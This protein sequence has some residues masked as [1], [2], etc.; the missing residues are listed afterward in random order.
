M[1]FECKYSQI[2]ECYRGWPNGVKYT[3]QVVKASIIEPAARIAT[4]KGIHG[5]GR[6]NI[7]VEGLW[8][9]NTQVEY[10]PRGLSTTFPRLIS[11][12][13]ENCGI[14]KIARKD[15]EG[16]GNL[17]DLSLS[18]NKLK[19]LP[20]D[21][22]V[23][24]PNLRQIFL[25]GNKILRLSSKILDPLNLKNLESFCLVGN[26]SIN[27]DFK[28]GGATTLEILMKEIDTKCLPPIE[29]PRQPLTKSENR[30]N[31][32][33]EYFL[34]GKFSDSIIKFRGKE[35]KVHKI[36]LLAQSSMIES[37]IRQRKIK[38]IKNMSDVAFED[39]LRYFYFGTIKSEDNAMV[40]FELAV[41]F[42]VASL[43]LE[44]EE[45]ILQNLNE[46]NMLKVFN[47]AHIRGS[48][49]LKKAA[50]AIIKKSFPEISENLID[51]PKIIK[52]FIN[53]KHR[54]DK[55]VKKYSHPEKFQERP[56]HTQ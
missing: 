55:A 56:C 50:F 30:F 19:V 42:D 17:E 46:V 1:E 8:I 51:D 27:V 15:F 5:A 23:E 49:V 13:V 37:I 40:L 41:E 16:L 32:L 9:E 29:E 34:T 14:K 20:N 28:Q 6:T 24:A 35:Y 54:I 25:H 33:R 7:D 11:V 39:F 2:F 12:L 26:P 38:K 22:F 53:V 45:I 10:F 18:Y 31:K 48:E 44:C 36:V 43:K 21:L 52:D 3:C 47:I 4:F